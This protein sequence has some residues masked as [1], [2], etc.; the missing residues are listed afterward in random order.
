M[1][2]KKFSMIVFWFCLLLL[3]QGKQL[4]AAFQQNIANIVIYNSFSQSSLDAASRQRSLAI[5]ATSLGAGLFNEPEA[6][7]DLSMIPASLRGLYYHRLGDWDNASIWYGTA[8]HGEP[9]PEQQKQLLIS[10]WMELS[11][12]GDFV[13]DALTKQ[14]HKRT[15]AATGTKLTWTDRGTLDFGCSEIAEE[16]K[17]A[18]L[19]WNQAFDIPYHHTLILR[20]KAEIGTILIL[21]TSIDDQLVRHLIHRGTGK[22][23]NF[24][25]PV[26]GDHVKYIYVHV[27]ED[28]DAPVRSCAGEIDSI[29]FLLD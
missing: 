1:N 24:T 16:P 7:G 11:P 2:L 20:A 27:R 12:T 13:L 3:L 23:E 9:V 21:E 18:V 19:E 17:N 10:P 28:R 6:A 15:D 22:W 8:A 26:E 14:W 5:A 29:S 4:V 25:V